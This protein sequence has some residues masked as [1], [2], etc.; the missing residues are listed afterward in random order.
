[1]SRLLY[2]PDYD[3]ST[4][5]NKF[6][7]SIKES[8]MSDS[9]KEYVLS[10]LKHVGP[11]MIRDHTFI[12]FTPNVTFPY[13]HVEV[14]CEDRPISITLD[15]RCIRYDCGTKSSVSTTDRCYSEAPTPLTKCDKI[16]MGLYFLAGI[17]TVSLY[18]YSSHRELFV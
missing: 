4:N 1:M 14:D 3:F 11:S 7:N 6:K 10:L 17:S 2:D 18:A 9:D 13:I 16:L 12:Y 15:N 5:M 8:G